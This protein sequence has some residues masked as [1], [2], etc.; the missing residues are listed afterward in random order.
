[1]RLPTWPIP[2]FA[3][4]L[5]SGCIFDTEKVDHPNAANLPTEHI[6]AVNLPTDPPED[7]V[8]AEPNAPE[9]QD[10][11]PASD[12]TKAIE[13][14]KSEPTPSLQPDEIQPPGER[15]PPQAIQ[16]SE[17]PPSLPEISHPVEARPTLETPSQPASDLLFKSNFAGESRECW[18]TQGNTGKFS[19]SGCGDFN[20]IGSE[21]VTLSENGISRSGGQAMEITYRKNEQQAGATLN[22]KEDVVHYRA[23]M[24]FDKGFDFGQGIKIGRVS[25]FNESKQENDIDII[26]LAGSKAG[27]QCGVNDMGFLSLHFNGRPAG[28]DWGSIEAPISFQ[29]ERWYAIE[30]QVSL[31]QAG[32]S[33]GIARIWVDGEM[34]A[35]RT[36]INI[37]GNLSDA[38][39]L[40]RLRVGG[41]YSNS[42]R[43][44][45][46]VDP[47]QPSRLYLDDIAVS[48]TYIGTR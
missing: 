9:N 39:K 3:L 40:N 25:G 35:E 16:S 1:M 20:S 34:V 22:I 17:E 19:P 43:G 4:V 13:V 11:L 33:N 44:N 21:G 10:S 31:N 37:R 38:V 15:Q 45:K 42:A 18:K 23:Y 29:R 14:E 2:V 6:E 41:W 5:F 30:F 27:D 12:T 7:S 47:S 8:L 24:Y 48:R 46:C 36:D 26:L 32:K 28:Y